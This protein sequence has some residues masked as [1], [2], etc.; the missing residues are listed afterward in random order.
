[1]LFDNISLNSLTCAN[2]FIGTRPR[3]V[4]V[5]A[6]ESQRL[7]FRDQTPIYDEDRNRLSTAEEAKIQFEEK[8]KEERRQQ[9]QKMEKDPM[10]SSSERRYRELIMSAKH[11]ILKQ[12]VLLPALFQAH[13]SKV[14]HQVAIRVSEIFDSCSGR[15]C[16]C[17]D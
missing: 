12:L 13:R 11:V 1:M 5:Q 10:S 3:C 4:R 8:E 17:P 2:L 16:Y 15:G 9:M 7:P 14:R 6:P